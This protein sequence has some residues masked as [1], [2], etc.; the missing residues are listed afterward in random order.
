MPPKRQSLSDGHKV[1]ARNRRARHDFDVLETVEA[2]IVLV[3]AEVKS[4]RAAQVQLRDSF[5]RVDN[6]EMWLHSVHIAPYTY[7]HGFGSFD[8][9]RKR[10]LLLHKAEIGRLGSRV[11]Q[12][13]LTLIPLSVYFSEGKAKVEIGLCKGRKTVDKRHAIAERDEARNAERE[14]RYERY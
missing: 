4:L 1:V 13:A 2:G 14:A 5:A 8:P 10:K 11:A 9:D 3:G 12:D 6:G 7:A